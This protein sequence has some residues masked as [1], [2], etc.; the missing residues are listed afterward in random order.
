M[1]NNSLYR[2]AF[3]I[4]SPGAKLADLMGKQSMRATFNLSDLA[5]RTLGI[6][7]RLLGIKTKVHSTN[8]DISG[9]SD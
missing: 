7:S 5:I 6:V 3:E 1:T 4:V 2:Q 8:P 9:S